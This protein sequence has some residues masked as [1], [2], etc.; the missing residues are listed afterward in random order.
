MDRRFEQAIASF[1]G[2]MDREG[3]NGAIAGAPGASLRA[4]HLSGRSPTR[5]AD[6]S[7]AAGATVG[8]S[9]VG[10]ADE[11]PLRLHPRLLE[12]DSDQSLFPILVERT[13]VRLDLHFPRAPGPTSSSS[14]GWTKS[15]SARGS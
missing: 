2:E 3:P 11:Q 4:D 6:R 9:R 10:Q 14:W 1:R 8:C 15:R 12:R 7:G 13:P 5:C